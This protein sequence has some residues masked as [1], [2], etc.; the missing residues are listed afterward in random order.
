MLANQEELVHYEK[1]TVVDLGSISEHT[2]LAGNSNNCKGGGDP[3]HLDKFCEWSG[4]T[5]ADWPACGGQ[6]DP[7]CG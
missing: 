3:Q 6:V 4:G 5:D 2:W 7:A 1:P